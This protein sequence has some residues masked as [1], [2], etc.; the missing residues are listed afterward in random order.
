MIQR[1]ARVEVWVAGIST[2]A[3]CHTFRHYFATHFLERC[4]YIHTI[5]ELHGHSDMKTLMIAT[6]HKKPLKEGVTKEKQ[7]R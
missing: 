6:E 4:A 5:Q 7:P 3:S 2:P 1:A